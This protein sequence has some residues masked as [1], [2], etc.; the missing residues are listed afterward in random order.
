MRFTFLVLMLLVFMLA[1]GDKE[2]T[3]DVK[4]ANPEL[5]ATVAVESLSV[6]IDP[7]CGMTVTQANLAGI[8]TFEG[9]TFGFC[10]EGCKEAF[11]KEP[12]VYLAK[13][14]QVPADS[15]HTHNAR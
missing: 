4:S 15:G 5:R 12:G 7:V 2:K 1:C 10:S 6:A 8:A 11:E 13:L 3:E 14:P 9:K